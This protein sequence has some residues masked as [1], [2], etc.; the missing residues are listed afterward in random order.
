MDL[1]NKVGNDTGGLVFQYAVNRF[2]MRK[3]LRWGRYANGVLIRL[4]MSAGLLWFHRQT[5]LERTSTSPVS[6]LSLRGL[7]SLAF[8]GLGSQVENARDL[9]FSLMFAIKLGG[10]G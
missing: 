8:F 3:K 7:N 10:N 9:H 5:L 2:I 6:F 4:I 1:M